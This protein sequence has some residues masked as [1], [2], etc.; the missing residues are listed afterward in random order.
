MEQLS[1]DEIAATRA[2]LKRDADNRE[3]TRRV[4]DIGKRIAFWITIVVAIV[5]GF[6]SLI[7]EY[8]NGK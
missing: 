6:R 5:G 2:M 3:F 4:R 8:L 7:W 1:D